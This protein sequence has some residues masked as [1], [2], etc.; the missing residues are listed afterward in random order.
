MVNSQFVIELKTNRCYK[1]HQ[2][3]WNLELNTYVKCEYQLLDIL[4]TA[5]V[6]DGSIQSVINVSYYS[7][8][9]TTLFHLHRLCNLECIGNET[10]NVEKVRIREKVVVFWKYDIRLDRRK[11]V[12]K[13]VVRTAVSSTEIRIIYR[14]RCLVGRQAVLTDMFCV[15]LSFSATNAFFIT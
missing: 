14:I 1:S 5:H 11:E 3:P 6:A 12:S 7:C 10:A 2:N 15:L 9:L 8:Y 4:D 13:V